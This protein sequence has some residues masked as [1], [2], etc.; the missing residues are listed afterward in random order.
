M[1]QT[2]TQNPI[3]DLMYDWI[4]I[5]H[6]KA[7]GLNAYEKYMKDAQDAPECMELLKKLHEQDV[8]MV[9]QVK[10]HLQM[11]MSKKDDKRH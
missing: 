10:D 2:Q 6:N 9:S 11:M 3:S 4:T 5:L 7:E 8:Q 1:Q